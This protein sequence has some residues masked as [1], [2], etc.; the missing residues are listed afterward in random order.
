MKFWPRWMLTKT[1]TTNAPNFVS[2]GLF[3]WLLRRETDFNTMELMTHMLP[4]KLTIYTRRLPLNDK[5]IHT[6]FC[7]QS[8]SNMY[9]RWLHVLA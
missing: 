7:L 4:R 1:T 2:I 8:E 5:E 6:K 9:A 3:S